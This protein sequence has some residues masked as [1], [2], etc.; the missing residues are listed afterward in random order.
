MEYFVTIEYYYY[1]LLFD[2]IVFAKSVIQITRHAVTIHMTSMT[3]NNRAFLPSIIMII[4]IDQ[5]RR[6]TYVIPCCI[7]IMAII[8]EI[9]MV[10]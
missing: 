5:I 1:Y 4:N 8:N 7:I 9:L 3:H 10:N 2:I 6:Y